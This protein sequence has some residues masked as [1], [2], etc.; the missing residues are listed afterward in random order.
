ME[1]WREIDKL[2]GKYLVS[3]RGRIMQ[4][5]RYDKY[6]RKAGGRI[7]ALNKRDKDGYAIAQIEQGGKSYYFRVHRLVAE[8]FIPN[9]ESKPQV[10]HINAIKDD[11][12]ASNLRWATPKENNNNPITI[13]N[14]RIAQTGKVMSR[15]SSARKS[16]AMEKKPVVKYCLSGKFVAIY[17]SVADAAKSLGDKSCCGGITNCCKG[18]SKTAR[19]FIWRY[20]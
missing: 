6:G 14:N 1:S 11:N 10:D 4:A 15:V 2:G 12:R 16:E 5:V 8:A 9:P 20:V 3:D 7:L 17:A 18:R 13:E 19:G